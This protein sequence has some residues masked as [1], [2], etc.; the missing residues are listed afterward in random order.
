MPFAQRQHPWGGSEIRALRFFAFEQDMA[1]SIY[2][3]CWYGSS[4]VHEGSFEQNVPGSHVTRLSLC[5]PAPRQ[6]AACDLKVRHTHRHSRRLVRTRTSEVP[7]VP[8]CTHAR[9]HLPV[10]RRTLLIRHVTCPRHR[11]ARPHLGLCSATGRGVHGV[12]RVRARAAAR[13]GKCRQPGR[14]PCVLSD[15]QPV[16][17]APCFGGLAVSGSRIGW[18]THRVVVCARLPRRS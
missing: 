3:D 8:V 2:L 13:R 16:A 9:V 18:F 1:L 17:A 5:T 4:L 10:S 11:P 7:H 6:C 12:P 15:T 14:Q